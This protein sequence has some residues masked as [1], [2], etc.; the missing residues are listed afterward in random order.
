MSFYQ[1]PYENEALRGCNA[2]PIQ[3]LSLEHAGG[4]PHCSMRACHNASLAMAVRLH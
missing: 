1:V 2:T 3:V 4:T